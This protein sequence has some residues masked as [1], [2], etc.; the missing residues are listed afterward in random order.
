[1]TSAAFDQRKLAAAAGS[2]DAATRAPNKPNK[3]AVSRRV[4]RDGLR[5]RRRVG[6]RNRLTGRRGER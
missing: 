6:K 5:K 2:A 3:K 4:I 1:M